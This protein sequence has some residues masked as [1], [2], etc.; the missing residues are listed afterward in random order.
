[1][2]LISVI[3][4]IYNAANYLDQAIRSVLGQ[5]FG[6]FELICVNDGSTDRSGEVLNK[7]VSHDQR[8]RLISQSNTGIVGALNAGLTVARCELIAR[9]DADDICLPMR[10]EKQVVYMNSHQ[11]CVAVGSTAV[12]IDQDASPIKRWEVPAEH[13]TI[14]RLH[15]EGMAGQIIHP[16]VLMRKS[17]IVAAGGYR[18]EWQWIED[19]DLFLRL[20]ELGKLANLQEDLL[21]YRLNICGVTRS[22]RKQQEHL[23]T[24]LCNQIRQQKGL[25]AISRDKIEAMAESKPDDVLAEWIEWAWRAGNYRTAQKHAKS[26]ICLRKFEIRSWRLFL[27]AYLGLLS[28]PIVLSKRRFLKRFNFQLL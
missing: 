3:I 28:T 23:T 10:F 5:S 18:P 15:L 27:K 25:P 20:A 9:M 17:A 19:Y 11:D 14:S 22:R 24:K 21:L 8:I 7:W 6:D 4:P 16:S 2:P 13:E 26:L 12:L 1:M